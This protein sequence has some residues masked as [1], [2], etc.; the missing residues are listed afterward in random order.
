MQL[1]DS[2]QWSKLS[3]NFSRIILIQF[4]ECKFC[5]CISRKIARSNANTYAAFFAYY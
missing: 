3:N 5:W 4:L 2:I 1:Y